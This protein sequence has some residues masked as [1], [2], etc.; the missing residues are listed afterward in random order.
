MKNKESIEF[1]GSAT[2]L[3][4]VGMIGFC[5]VYQTMNNQPVEIPPA[6][7]GLAGPIITSVTKDKFQ[8]RNNKNETEA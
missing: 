6:L 8:F 3:A 2:I 5:V 4:F 7:L 1:V